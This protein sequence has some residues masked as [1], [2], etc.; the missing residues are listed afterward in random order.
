MN[1]IGSRPARIVNICALVVASIV[2]VEGA[3]IVHERIGIFRPFDYWGPF[4]P[5]FVMLV[6]RNRTFS[7]CFLLLYVAL[8]IELFS[9][10]RSAYLGTYNYPGAKDPLEWLGIFFV[11]S[12]ICLAS[13]LGVTLLRAVVRIARSRK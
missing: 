11:F 7:F 9:R 4:V 8:S 5:A 2:L 10:A 3:Y 12:I 13:Y 6:V 1:L